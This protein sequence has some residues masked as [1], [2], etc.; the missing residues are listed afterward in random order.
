MRR[1][2]QRGMR[3]GRAIAARSLFVGGVLAW[4]ILATSACGGEDA[5]DRTRT[6]DAS[7][8]LPSSEAPAR[9]PTEARP[10]SVDFAS[11]GFD[12]GDPAAPVR[13]LE[14]SDFGCGYCRKFH[15]ETWP[16]LRDEFVK[17]GKVQWKFVPFVTGMFSHSGVATTAAECALEQGPEAFE[18]IRT[19]LWREQSSWKKAGDAAAL[20][21][22]WAGEEGLDLKRYDGCVAGDRPSSRMSAGRELAAQLGVRGT[23]TFF[24]VGYPPIPGALPTETFRKVLTLVYEDATGQGG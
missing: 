13:I 20:L 4:V 7:R 8:E 5:A 11:L 2:N 23:P 18:A 15:L 3:C 10:A 21:R 17:T 24:I 12:L 1:K 22:G 19:R 6:G 16:V 9:P 14:M